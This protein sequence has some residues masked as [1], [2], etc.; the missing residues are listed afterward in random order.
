MTTPAHQQKETIR[1][2]L[3]IPEH[4]PR[5]SDPHYSAFRAFERR[6]K[7]Q[8]LDICA[9]CGSREKVEW[10]HSA[11]EFS[12]INAVDVQKFDELY[13]LHLSDEEF[14]VWVESPSNAEALCVLHHRG[15]EGV[16]LLPEPLWNALRVQKAGEPIVRTE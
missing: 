3:T 9:V 7:A 12:L 10:H 6:A 11:I 16:H 4:A 1:L 2:L 8:G 15:Q 13:G 5:A 14:K